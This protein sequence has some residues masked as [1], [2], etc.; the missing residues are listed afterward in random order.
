MH[1]VPFAQTLVAKLAEKPDLAT[2]ALLAIIL[3]LSLKILGFFY[4]LVMYWVRMAVRLA[5]LAALLAAGT[6][7]ATRGIDGA[8]DDARY[9]AGVWTKEYRRYQDQVEQAREWQMQQMQQQQPMAG[10]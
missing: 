5:L 10:R 7:V 3:W 9:W 6:Y 2:L 8:A 1:V 4:G